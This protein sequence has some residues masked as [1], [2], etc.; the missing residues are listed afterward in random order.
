MKFL[1]NSKRQDF[2]DPHQCEYG[3]KE[4]RQCFGHRE[5][6]CSRRIGFDRVKFFSWFP[7][8]EHDAMKNFRSFSLLRSRVEK[9]L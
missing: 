9:H 1:R 8:T 2:P 7:M 3:R 6:S 4:I 5:V